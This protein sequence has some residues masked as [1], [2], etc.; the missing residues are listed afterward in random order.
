MTYVNTNIN[1]FLEISAHLTGFS[2]TE[3]EATGMLN[4]YY[5]TILAKTS[6]ENVE[7]F[8]K[9]VHDILNDPEQ[10][11]QLEESIKMQLM[12]DHL[13]NALAKNIIMLWYTGSLLNMAANVPFFTSNVVNAEAYKQGLMWDAAHA[14]PPGAKQ[15]GYG[16]WANLPITV[17]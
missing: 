11:S 15:P 4:T 9:N 17:K 5:D 7:F 1:L 2:K 10:T 14:H 12:P 6:G 8:F 3:L 13:Y 16:S